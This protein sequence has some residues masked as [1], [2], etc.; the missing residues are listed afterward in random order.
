[1]K[2][3]RDSGL[4]KSMPADRRGNSLKPALE[5][6]EL[7]YRGQLGRDERWTGQGREIQRSLSLADAPGAGTEVEKK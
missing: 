6:S 2:T 3:Q 1:M 5:L 7:R 4:K